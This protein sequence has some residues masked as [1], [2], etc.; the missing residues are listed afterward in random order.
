LHYSNGKTPSI[1]GACKLAKREGWKNTDCLECKYF[2]ELDEE[3]KKQMEVIMDMAAGITYKYPSAEFIFGCYGITN[4]VEK[5]IIFK[6]AA[7]IVLDIQEIES[8]K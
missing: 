1:C 4:S 8:K 5:H 3:N 6:K 2:V 7:A